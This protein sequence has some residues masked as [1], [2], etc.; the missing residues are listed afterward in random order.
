MFEGSLISSV[1]VF[2]DELTPIP[3]LSLDFVSGQS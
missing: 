2:A 3:H 1:T